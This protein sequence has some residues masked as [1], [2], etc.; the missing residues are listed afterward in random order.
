VDYLA[1]FGKLLRELNV[2]RLRRLL[3]ILG[4]IIGTAAV[5]ASLAVVEGGRGQ[6]YSYIEKLGVNVVFL[7]DRYEPEAFYDAPARARRRGCRMAWAASGPTG[8]R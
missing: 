2:N 1:L 5:I 6:L 4:V 8:S 7:E 3:S